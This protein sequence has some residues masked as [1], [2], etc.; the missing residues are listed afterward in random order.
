MQATARAS[1]EIGFENA[2]VPEQ[3]V[4]SAGAA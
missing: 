1:E 4:R 2:P 3:T